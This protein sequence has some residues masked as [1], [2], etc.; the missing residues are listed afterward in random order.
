MKAI[1]KIKEVKDLV[2]SRE[3][4]SAV[5]TKLYAYTDT[6]NDDL[7]LLEVLVITK[8]GTSREKRDE[9]EYLLENT[10]G[11]IEVYV[12]L[13]KSDTRSVIEI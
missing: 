3:D 7:D 12:E 5:V 6:M 2:N 11:S 4:L 8:P 10:V 1:E 13:N 9:I